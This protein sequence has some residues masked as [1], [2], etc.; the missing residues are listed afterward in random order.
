MLKDKK[1]K[2]QKQYFQNDQY[3]FIEAAIYLGL[4]TSMK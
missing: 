2:F 1:G 3:L 4:L